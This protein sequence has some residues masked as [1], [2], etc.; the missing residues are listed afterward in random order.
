MK[1]AI[2]HVVLIAGILVLAYMV[3]NSIHKVT[4]FNSE[5]KFRKEVVGEKMKH[6][7]EIQSAYKAKYKRY[8][9]TWDTLM[10]FLRKDSLPL[11]LKTGTVPDSL[12]EMKAI[13]MGLVTRD[14]SYM[15]AKDSLFF[16]K[17][18]KYELDELMLIPFSTNEGEVPADTFKID[19]GS[20]NRGNINVP[21]FEIVA[22]KQSYLKGL[23]E[24]LIAR[25]KSFDLK[26][27]SMQEAT[28]DGNWE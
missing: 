14:T 5:E 28:T 20:L 7:R 11:V 2:L 18:R 22:P 9:P 15:P 6:I 26:V 10:T 8:S 4:S 24:E 23:N 12:T 17:E 27:G 25:E 19:A 16:N 1:R 21:V 3:Y 13:E